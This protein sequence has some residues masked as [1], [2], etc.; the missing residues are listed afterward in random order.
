MDIKYV[1]LKLKLWGPPQLFSRE[2]QA[3]WQKKMLLNPSAKDLKMQWE[4]PFFDFVK[5][6]AKL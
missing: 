6:E 3:T 5:Y 2:I 4:I 1:M